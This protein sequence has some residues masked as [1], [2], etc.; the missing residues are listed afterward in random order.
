LQEVLWNQL[1][2]PVLMLLKSKLGKEFSTFACECEQLGILQNNF[3]QLVI[4]APPAMRDPGL[5]CSF[6]A[7]AVV[8]A[9]NHFG[10]AGDLVRAERLA[11]WALQIEPQHVPAMSS[12]LAVAT[13]RKDLA[14]QHRLRASIDSTIAELRALPEQQLSA[15]QIG[16]IRGVVR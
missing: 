10:G 7:S 11:S 2:Q 4:K 14:A 9:A 8:S 5:I 3:V 6:C 16:V 1:T 13:Y 15:F 12:L